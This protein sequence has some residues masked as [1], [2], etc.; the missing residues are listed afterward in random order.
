MTHRCI[1]ALLICAALA[2][3]CSDITMAGKGGSSETVNAKVFI[4]DST[5][6]VRVDDPATEGLSLQI[7]SPQYRPLQQYGFSDSVSC[8]GS[9]SIIWNA[10]QYNTNNLQI[11]LRQSGIACFLRDISVVKG[12]SD[13]VSCVLA[14]GRDLTGYISTTNPKDSSVLY[15]LSIYG[16][17]YYS[18]SDS[19]L[20]FVI[21]NVPDGT[22]KLSVH[23]M[24][25]RLFNPVSNYT[26]VTDSIGNQTNLKVVLP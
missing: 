5:I 15:E 7:Y 20:N 26:V 9:N 25:K 2:V 14:E 13:T 12:Q 21:K 16:S 23:S 8:V 3:Q 4:N 18:V 17:P 11:R 6:S 19:S 1:R 10:H 24:E 22:Y